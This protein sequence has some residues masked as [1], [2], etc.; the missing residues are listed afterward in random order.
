MQKFLSF[1]L[2]GKYFK[3]LLQGS[4]FLLLVS[5]YTLNSHQTGKTLGKGNQSYQVLYGL[6]DQPALEDDINLESN[7]LMLP[8]FLLITGITDDFDIGATLG[9]N[10]SGFFTKYQFVGNQESKFAMSTGVNGFVGLNVFTILSY[11][12][13]YSI[14][15]PLYLSYEISPDFTIYTTPSL[16]Y[17]EGSEQHIYFNQFS[18]L[19]EYDFYGGAILGVSSELSDILFISLEATCQSPLLHNN[20]F[21]YLTAGFGLKISALKKEKK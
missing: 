20:Y 21:F 8:Q 17:I 15:L 13:Y 4:F 12:A 6:V 2:I 3:Y 7:G 1:I 16:N 5:C 19:L 18:A 11:Q 9:L 10:K 14:E